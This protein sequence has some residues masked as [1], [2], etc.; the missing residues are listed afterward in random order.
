MS[1]QQKAPQ[2][3]VQGGPGQRPGGPAPSNF[4]FGPG[5]GGPGAM[6]M[7]VQKAKDFKGTLRRLTGYLR[8]HRFAYSS[9]LLRPYSVPCSRFS[10]RRS[11]ARRR[12]SCSTGLV[13]KVQGACGSG[14]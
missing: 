2:A 14:K 6:G 12:R 4:G 13:G 8:P 7:P 3:A 1:E 5:R 10:A 9:C 11:W